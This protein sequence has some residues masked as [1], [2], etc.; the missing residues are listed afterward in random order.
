M[1][2]V[3]SNSWEA[4]VNNLCTSVADSERCQVAVEDHTCVNLLFT[5]PSLYA[6][7]AGDL[8]CQLCPSAVQ[9][10]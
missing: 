6:P 1:S 9:M 5:N 10:I 8:P 7:A 2:L 4:A 3:A